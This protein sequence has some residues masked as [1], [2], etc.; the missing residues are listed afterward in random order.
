VSS[1]LPV[2]LPSF[3][4]ELPTRQARYR[5]YGKCG[6]ITVHGGSGRYIF[7]SPDGGG[8]AHASLVI[9]TDEIADGVE[10]L[11]EATRMLAGVALRSMDVLDGEVSLPQFRVLA[12]L[13]DLG[14]VRSVRVAAALS[15]EPSTVTRLVDRLVAA[16]H[17][18][19][20]TDPSNRS[21]VI[22]E[23]TGSGR[24]LVADV[25]AWRRQELRR[26]L[27]RLDPSARAALTVSVHQLVEAAGEGYGAAPHGPVPL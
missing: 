16:G 1:G 23:L 5:P 3:L 15:L 2:D 21:A 12:V 18:G 17:V 6:C 11:Q 8:A 9:V 4:D 27:L 26:I 25:A 14:Q 7:T 19:R 20:S 24:R 10:A 13:A 22:L